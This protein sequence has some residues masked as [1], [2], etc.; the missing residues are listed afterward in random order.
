M[1]A[2]AAESDA[3]F[4]SRPRGHQIGAF[5]SLQSQ[6][7]KGGRQEV[8][9]KARLLEAKFNT[10]GEQGS[11]GS[12]PPIP[13]PDNWGGFLIQPE[14]IEFWQGRVSRLHDRILYRRQ[15]VADDAWIIER[16]WA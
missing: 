9:E 5:A 11:E 7:V 14:S 10:T 3:Y 12:L 16:L 6:V 2:P 13:R 1:K 8:E 15:S 4:A